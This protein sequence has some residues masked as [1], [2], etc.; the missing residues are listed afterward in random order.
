MNTLGLL[1][2]EPSPQDRRFSTQAKNVSIWRSQ[3][4][5][6]RNKAVSD[7]FSWRFNSLRRMDALFRGVK[8]PG[9]GLQLPV[10]CECFKHGSPSEDERPRE[11]GWVT[12]CDKFQSKPPTASAWETLYALHT[13]FRCYKMDSPPSQWAT[14]LEYFKPPPPR[15]NGVASPQVIAWSRMLGRVIS[16][17]KWDRTNSLLAD[18]FDP[19]PDDAI[20]ALLRE[21]L[22]ITEHQPRGSQVRAARRVLTLEDNDSS[23]RLCCQ[24]GHALV[25]S[26][27]LPVDSIEL[28]CIGPCTIALQESLKRRHGSLSAID[29]NDDGKRCVS[30]VGAGCVVWD[31]EVIGGRDR[32]SVVAAQAVAI[33]IAKTIFQLANSAS[34]RNRYEKRGE[35]GSVW[36]LPPQYARLFVTSVVPLYDAKLARALMRKRSNFSS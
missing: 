31:I 23:L 13:Q 29:L 18:F 6:Y 5:D 28:A 25:H 27:I 35:C 4:W 33:R 10:I 16:Y 15:C 22:A 2:F 9:P 21:G 3:F 26:R 34:T 7:A 30:F 24:A 17:S 32:N 36:Q 20:I 8:L 1:C 14:Q 12:L 11:D 19:T